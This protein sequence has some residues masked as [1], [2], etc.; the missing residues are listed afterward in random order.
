MKQ[1]FLPESLYGVDLDMT[2]KKLSVFY[3]S[4]TSITGK[5]TRLDSE[6]R[7]L[8][9]LIGRNLI[10]YIPFYEATIY[11]IYK[12]N[13]N[14]SPNIYSLVGKT[15]RAKIIN[16]ETDNIILS[17]KENMLEALSYI[18]EQERIEYAT[19]TGMSRY[20]AFFDI[21]AGILGRCY[22]KN[23]TNI[24]YD[25]I[26]DI[27]LDK[28][29]IIPVSIISFN[30]ENK[31]FE[32]SRIN[33][34]PSVFEELNRNDIIS[35]TI[36]GPV[37]DPDNIGYFVDIDNSDIVGI[38]DSHDMFQKGDKIV[39]NIKKITEKGPKLILMQTI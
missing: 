30:Q 34:L 3:E 31:N 15:I 27:G 33:N 28:G 9:V 12:C 29:D 32:L 5:V 39:C 17:R 35:G 19:I 16:L 13:G 7:V 1:L 4:Q 23:Y 6:N 14:L 38:V 20:M 10:G 36:S 8:E 2:H 25:N 22:G 26:K 21:G 24:L 37:N 11:P 18:K